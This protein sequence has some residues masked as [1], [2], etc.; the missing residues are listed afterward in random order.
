MF[1]HILCV[2]VC[3]WCDTPLVKCR[4]SS[5]NGS[6]HT[7]QHARVHCLSSMHIR[8][9]CGTNAGHSRQI[10]TLATK[11]REQHKRLCGL[12]PSLLKMLLDKNAF[13]SEFHIQLLSPHYMHSMS[14]AIIVSADIYEVKTL[15]TLHS[16]TTAVAGFVG[17][18][19][20]I[21][22]L[23]SLTDKCATIRMDTRRQDV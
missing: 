8:K 17:W 15:H 10:W 18:F 2:C 16:N 4:K 22:L 12:C 3:V 13:R 14:A 23:L 6:C 21:F 7:S 9:H 20:S 5:A 19:L 1:V 11:R